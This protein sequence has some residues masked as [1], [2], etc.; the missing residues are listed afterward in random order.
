MPVF[1]V[2][3]SS[4]FL[5]LS[6]PT[7]MRGAFIDDGEKEKRI[8]NRRKESISIHVRTHAL[9]HFKH[10]NG[11]GE[12]VQNRPLIHLAKGKKKLRRSRK[13][14][15]RISEKSLRQKG[16]DGQSTFLPTEVPPR[17]SPA[18]HAPSSIKIERDHHLSLFRTRPRFPSLSLSKSVRILSLSSLLLF[19]PP[20]F[21]VVVARSEPIWSRRS[22]TFP[23]WEGG[24]R[25]EHSLPATESFP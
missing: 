23:V 18:Q 2:C 9:C 3:S 20:R 14:G 8:E 1:T 6:A 21:S 19:F 4:F 17:Y 5:F 15:K 11:V 13:N 16:S 25:H 10:G 12:V 22:R 7:L 24:S